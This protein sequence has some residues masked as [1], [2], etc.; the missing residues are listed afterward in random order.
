MVSNR[1]VNPVE[2][3][4]Q[5]M[6]TF[7]PINTHAIATVT[8]A[9]LRP[10]GLSQG[11]L[12]AALGR[13]QATISRWEKGIDTDGIGPEDISTMSVLFGR[14]ATEIVLAAINTKRN[15]PQKIR[16]EEEDN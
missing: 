15:P 8:L 11:T 1:K 16:L 2:A 3:Y 10:R 9:D 4:L 6:H 12:A 7:P 14:E 5:V 13:S